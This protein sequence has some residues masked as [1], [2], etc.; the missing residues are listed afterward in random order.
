MSDIKKIPEYFGCNVFNDA[1]MREYLP[2]RVYQQL[3]EAIDKLTDH[4]CSEGLEEEIR[5]CVQQQSDVL[6][7]DLL[8]T[9]EFGRKIYLDLEVRMDKNMLLDVAHQRAERLHDTIEDRFPQSLNACDPISV[10]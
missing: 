8:K 10:T 6:G 3:R 1:A 2:K 7:I 9:R 4:A 5:Q